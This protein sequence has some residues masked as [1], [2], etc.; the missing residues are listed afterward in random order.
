[1]LTDDMRRVW[2]FDMDGEAK[3]TDTGGLP[4]VPWMGEQYFNMD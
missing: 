2:I 1:M 4:S 3:G